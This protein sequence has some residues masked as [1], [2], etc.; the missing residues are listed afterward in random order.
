MEIFLHFLFDTSEESHFHLQN[1]KFFLLHFIFCYRSVFSV[2]SQCQ[3]KMVL[4]AGHHQPTAAVG[5]RIAWLVCGRARPTTLG[6][7]RHLADFSRRFLTVPLFH[8]APESRPNVQG[9]ERED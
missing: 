8:G 2:T 7:R 5:S 4:V 9:V 3:E 6:D 1:H